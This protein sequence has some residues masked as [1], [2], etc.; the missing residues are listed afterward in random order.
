MKKLALIA[1]AILISTPVM[2]ADPVFGTWQTAKDD[3]GNY[4]HI[5]VAQCGNKICGKLVK[6]FKSDG[7]AGP[8]ENIGKNIIWDMK[9]DGGGAYSG[10]KIWSPDRDKTYKSKM[11]MTGNKI[12]VKGCIAFICRDG[13][14]WTRV[15]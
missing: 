3:N 1:A 15:N 13:G 9:S 2:A 12:A 10:G 5:E 11:R 4:G 7:S 8:T 6:S 14:T